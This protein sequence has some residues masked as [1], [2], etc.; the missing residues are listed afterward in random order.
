MTTTRKFF[1]NT[2]ITTTED[3]KRLVSTF[4]AFHFVNNERAEALAELTAIIDEYNEELK[5]SAVG[6]IANSDDIMTALV[7]SIVIDEKTAKSNNARK[8]AVLNAVSYTQYKVDTEKNEIRATVRAVTVRDVFAYKCNL[9]ASK[10]ADRKI[11][12]DDREKAK[13]QV[14]TEEQTNA[15]RLFMIGAFRFENVADATN[16]TYN[17]NATDTEENALFLTATPS[18]ANAEK[19][20]KTTASALGLG[21]I[22]FKRAHALT[23]YKRAYTIDK[24]HQ[25]KTVDILDFMQDFAISARYA[26]NNIALPEV[27]DRAGIFANEDTATDSD[28]VFKF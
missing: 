27:N 14:L 25:A 11:T 3:I 12:K 16:V 4:R 26:K 2:T 18:K 21:E 6:T 20:I 13:K 28:N 1:V 24:G 5:N 23:L 17:F 22:N 10:H 7:P 9:L 19:Q 8:R 15:L